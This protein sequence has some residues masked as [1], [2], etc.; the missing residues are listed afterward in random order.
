MTHPL[1]PVSEIQD[2]GNCNVIGPDVSGS[3]TSNSVILG[4]Q[5]LFNGLTFLSGAMFSGSGSLLMSASNI[6]INSRFSVTG[7]STFKGAVQ[8]SSPGSLN[9]GAGVTATFNDGITISAGGANIFQGITLHGEFLAVDTVISGAA[10]LSIAGG[11]NIT[12]GDMDVLLGN[13]NVPQG[14]ATIQGLVT[15]NDGLVVNVNGIGCFGGLTVYTGPTSCN[16]GLTVSGDLTTIN[17]GLTVATGLTTCAAGLSVTSGITCAGGI[18]V[19]TGLVTMDAG[20]TV[21]AGNATVSAG[22]LI[23]SA[24]VTSNGFQLIN[25]AAG[26]SF[27]ANNSAAIQLTGTAASDV[28]IVIPKRLGGPIIVDGTAVLGGHALNVT[29]SG[30]TPINLAALP[31]MVSGYNIRA[32]LYCDGANVFVGS[33]G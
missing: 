6:G 14:T 7:S 19:T 2:I 4:V 3:I 30:G 8:I 13:L 5:P 1:I 9:C 12:S 18:N 15:C 33:A 24:G 22:Q 10:G 21:A 25:V 17:D 26:G 23:I 31:N 20:L 27:T 11:A 28:T 16:D 29:T 32:V